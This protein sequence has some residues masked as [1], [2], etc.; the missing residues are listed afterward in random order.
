MQGKARRGWGRF[1]KCEHAKLSTFWWNREHTCKK[2]RSK[3]T[4]RNSRARL[5]PRGYQAASCDLE[6]LKKKLA[7]WH[8]VMA[9][10]PL[11]TSGMSKGDRRRSGRNMQQTRALIGSE[12]RLAQILILELASI[13][14]IYYYYRYRPVH[15]PQIS[16]SYHWCPPHAWKMRY[17][18]T[19]K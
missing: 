12:R 13:T 10:F 17:K 11:S 6:Q 4:I 3:C 2:P 16:K 18:I 14:I 8:I 19:T 7:T 1:F 9:L 15:S 5:A